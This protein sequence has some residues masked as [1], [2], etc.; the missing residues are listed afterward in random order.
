MDEPDPFQ[1]ETL[2]STN[3]LLHD[4]ERKLSFVLTASLTQTSNSHGSVVHDPQMAGLAR[5][6]IQLSVFSYIRD[7]GPAFDADQVYVDRHQKF[8]TKFGKDYSPES[9]N[10]ESSPQTP[11][12]DAIVHETAEKSA[13]SGLD[14][15]PR[16][17]LSYSES[18]QKHLPILPT[19]KMESLQEPLTKKG[20]VALD[21]PAAAS[22]ADAES[23]RASFDL[24]LEYSESCGG[25][26]ACDGTDAYD[27]Y[28][29]GEFDSGEDNYG[30]DDFGNEF[31]LNESYDIDDSDITEEQLLPPLPPRLPPR[32]MDPDKLYG[33]YEF[34]GPDPLHCTL[35][36]DEP[37]FLMNDLD[38][39]WWLIRK[40]SKAERLRLWH[41][42]GSKE[43]LTSDEE[44][45]KIGFVP[46]E[47]LETYGERLARLNCHKNE[48]LEKSSRENLPFDYYK[49][50]SGDFLTSSQVNVHDGTSFDDKLHENS[51]DHAPGPSEYAG[52][53][54]SN[55]FDSTSNKF[56]STSSKFDSMSEFKQADV[57]SLAEGLPL[58]RKGSILKKSRGY[59]QSNKLVTFENLGDLNLD[60]DDSDDD[61]IDFSDHYFHVGHDDIKQKLDVQHED[62]EKLSEVLSDV[63]PVNAMLQINKSPRKLASPVDNTFNQGRG[64]LNDSLFAPPHAIGAGDADSIGTYSPDTPPTDKF[65]SPREEFSSTNIRRTQILDRLSRVT[66]DIQDQIGSSSDDGDLD[67]GGALA[68]LSDHDNTSVFAD[69]SGNGTANAIGNSYYNESGLECDDEQKDGNDVDTPLTSMNSLSNLATLPA[70]LAQDRRKPKPVHDMFMPILGKL[71]E[72]TEKLAELEQHLR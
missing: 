14:S 10:K 60:D 6:N 61:D 49:N 68:H 35:A 4:L 15:L 67:F 20:N 34:S 63:Y 8:L 58:G 13:V 16:P 46:A 29:D 12:N 45:G 11:A 36:R 2:E 28:Y 9:G 47:C 56:D 18:A 37:V 21:V 17:N 52:S 23:L 30:D 43:D 50:G 26:E 7:S 66:S 59:R 3:K 71:D 55:N 25:S 39:Y 1:S 65:K 41:T 32:E 38:N 57:K 22:T 31:S 54:T 19:S 69:Y 62:P 42:R 5:Y 70:P 51:L 40:M 64:V 53:T 27:D 48:E 33:L 24:E 44:D 72:L